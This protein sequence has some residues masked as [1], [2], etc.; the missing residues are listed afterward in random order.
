MQVMGLEELIPQPYNGLVRVPG[1]PVPVQVANG[2]ATVNG[3]TYLVNQDG[4]VTKDGQQVGMVQN[5]MFKPLNQG[6]PN[7]LG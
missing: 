5:G 6:N 2:K 7:G 4:K 1:M 3:Q